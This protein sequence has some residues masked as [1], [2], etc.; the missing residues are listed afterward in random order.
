MRQLHLNENLYT[1]LVSANLWCQYYKLVL[2]AINQ[3]K[4]VDQH[5]L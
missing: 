5:V 3:T 1:L 4:N 2:M